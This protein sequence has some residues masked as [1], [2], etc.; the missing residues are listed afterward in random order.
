[1]EVDTIEDLVGYLWPNRNAQ[2]TVDGDV[3]RVGNLSEQ[4]QVRTS[5]EAEETDQGRLF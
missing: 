2:Y 1:V 4:S 5:T 3:E